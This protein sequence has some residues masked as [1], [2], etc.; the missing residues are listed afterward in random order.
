M[1]GLRMTYGRSRPEQERNML[2]PIVIPLDDEE[3][4]RISKFPEHSLMRR[5]DFQRLAAETLVWLWGPGHQDR[6]VRKASSRRGRGLLRLGP[7]GLRHR[8]PLRGDRSGRNQG[9]D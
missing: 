9:T 2:M 5:V 1:A 8:R 4:I 3:P 6:R 7:R